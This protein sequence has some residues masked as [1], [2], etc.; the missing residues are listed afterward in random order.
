MSHSVNTF[1]LSGVPRLGVKLNHHKTRANYTTSSPISNKDIDMFSWCGL[2]IDTKT[3]EIRLDGDRFSGSLATDNVVIHRSGKEGSALSKKM[4]DFVKPRC[5][6][7]LLFS[8]FVN[9]PDTIRIN[10]YQTF[11]L[12]AIKT[13][14]YLKNTGSKCFDFVHRIACNT[15]HYSFRL[16][17]SNNAPYCLTLKEAM[18]LGRH[19]FYTIIGREDDFGQLQCLFREKRGEPI[20]SRKELLAASKKALNSWSYNH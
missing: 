19:A 1:S 6:Q 2:L 8:S 4:K 9:G 12:C 5:R 13:I 17:S 20:D 16:I 10:F 18:W 15:I 7:Q 11:M 3:C 14:H